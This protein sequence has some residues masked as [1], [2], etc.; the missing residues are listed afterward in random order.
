[1][2]PGAMIIDISCDDYM[3]IETS[4]STTIE[5]PI[6]I[7]DGILH[8]AVDH[9]P[10]LLY[11][12]ATESISAALRPF[13]N[14]LIEGNFNP[15]LEK[16]TIIKNGAILDDRITCFQRRDSLLIADKVY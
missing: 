10:A 14:D 16:A 5:N 2:K 4:H 11:K 15:V 9:T 7:V 8:Y 1:M 3:G 12:T 13:L 6:Y